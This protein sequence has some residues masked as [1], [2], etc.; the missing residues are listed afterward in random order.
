A[1]VLV[2]TAIGMLVAPA[3]VALFAPGSL[4]EPE[5]FAATTTMLRITFPYLIFISLTALAGGVLNSNGRFA[6]PALT[7][8]LHNLAVIA[9]ALWL[10]PLLGMSI[11]ALAWGVFGA[12]V[13]QLVV[14]WLALARIGAVPRLRLDLRHEGVRRVF[15]L[16]LPTIFS[17]SAAQI[18][19]IVGTAFASLLATGSQTWLYL[20]DRLLEFPLGMFGVALGT[21][22]LPHL[23]RR[24][25]ATDTV[26]YAQ[27]LD[28][29]MRM[30]LLVALPAAAGL[31]ALAEPINATLYQYGRFTPFDTRMTALSLVAMSIGLPGF[32]LAKVLAPAF[33]ARQDTRTPVRAALWTVVANL[34]FGIAIVGPLWWYE[35][36]GAHAGIAL[37]T[38]L[39]GIVNAALLW[40]YLRRQGIA[41][42]QR[43]WGRFL[44]QLA[45]AVS[46]MVVV[47]VVARAQVG[48]WQQLAPYWRIAHLAWVIGAATA[49]YALALLALG[50]RPGH[51]RE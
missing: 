8:V 6:V 50:L 20:T 36:E 17:S 1:A 4:D 21:V 16:M 29:G 18:N 31:I 11:T 42:P 44:A 7:P 51:L 43:G 30:V 41:A 35:V 10:A 14:Q 26:G 33:F 9:A 13:V 48:P 45:V 38:A 5:K 47:L 49:T 22:I 23:S 27:A 37:A 32:M 24:H 19:L 3:I 40:R 25:A 2:V 15:R 12:G 28:W 46:A 34:V 39:A